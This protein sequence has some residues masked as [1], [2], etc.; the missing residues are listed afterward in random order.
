MST[1]ITFPGSSERKPATA[2]T[3]E[4]AFLVVEQTEFGPGRS[5]KAV[6]VDIDAHIKARKAYRKKGPVMK[7]R[8]R[9]I[10]T[11]NRQGLARRPLLRR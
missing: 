11:L 6:Q 1:I 5:R 8:R 7:S 9:S 4:P 10:R 2:V 3:A